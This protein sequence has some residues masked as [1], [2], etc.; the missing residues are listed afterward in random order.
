[1]Q[2][3]RQQTDERRERAAGNSWKH[4][5]LH[6]KERC[7]G[8]GS[9]GRAQ[10][11]R[12]NLLRM[13]VKVPRRTATRFSRG[14]ASVFVYTHICVYVCVF[15]FVCIYVHVHQYIHTHLSIYAHRMAT[16]FSRR[17]VSVCLWRR[18]GEY[19]ASKHSDTRARAS[20]CAFTEGGSLE[21]FRNLRLMLLCVLHVQ[22]IRLRKFDAPVEEGEK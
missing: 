2:T 11:G 16:R 20:A 22:L 19:V 13:D 6:R 9:T 4:L 1:M 7:I 12:E 21:C 18:D 3:D 5:L 8:V 15:T 17:G 10:G 14:R